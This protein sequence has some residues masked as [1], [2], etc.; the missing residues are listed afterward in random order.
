MG[1]LELAGTREEARR[2]EKDGADYVGVGPVFAT[3]TKPDAGE[4]LGIE[5][6]AAIAASISI[7]V[8]AIGGITVENV[9]AVIGAGAAGAAGVSAVAHAEDMAAAARAL[10]RRITLARAAAP[11]GAR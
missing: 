5:A 4:P 9:E 2:A 3:A 11:G 7:P 8:I 6:F 10:K 1:D